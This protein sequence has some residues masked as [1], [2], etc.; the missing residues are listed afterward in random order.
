MQEQ[1]EAAASARPFDDVFTQSFTTNYSDVTLADQ[2]T[3]MAEMKSAGSSASTYLPDLNITGLDTSVAPKS[4]AQA[5]SRDQG[6]LA[7]ARDYWNSYQ[8]EAVNEGGLSGFAKYAW[9]RA[10]NAVVDGVQVAKDARDYWTD[11]ERNATSA[12]E[13]IFAGAMHD[14]LLPAALLDRVGAATNDVLHVNF[15][16][17]ESGLRQEVLK[18]FPTTQDAVNAVNWLDQQ[19]PRDG[20][21]ATEDKRTALMVALAS[22]EAQKVSSD[23]L[24]QEEIAY[25][26][27][28]QLRNVMSN[29]VKDLPDAMKGRELDPD[30]AAAEHFFEVSKRVASS[31]M[32]LGD[33]EVP[34]NRYVTGPAWATIGAGYAWAKRVGILGGSEAGE[35]QTSWELAGIM[36]GWEINS[37]GR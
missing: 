25:D 12:G 37:R 30:L 15:N 8:D 33:F 35:H 7:T 31:Q 29:G 2:R 18:G 26:R 3:A 13:A 24:Q 20:T 6:A 9:G 14:I 34:T 21:A 22:A 4:V 17:V 27:L 36:R 28:F 1:F 5:D 23:P 19:I 16:Q 11:A 10:M 32:E